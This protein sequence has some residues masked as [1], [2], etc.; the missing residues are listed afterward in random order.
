M[1]RR[2]AHRRGR[3]VAGTRWRARSIAAR[4]RRDDEHP[5]APPRVLGASSS[6]S[7]RGSGS[8]TQDFQTMA[9]TG[10][11]EDRFQLIWGV[12]AAEPGLLQLGPDRR[13]DRRAWPRTESGRSRSCGGPRSG[14][15]PA[16][17]RPPARRTAATSRRG[18]TSSRR[19]WRAT[20]AGGSY[21]ATDYRAAIRRGRQAAA[22]PVLADLER[23]QPEEVLRAEPIGREVRPA[24]RISHDAIKTKDPQAQIVL[25][26][27]PG[28][29]D[30]NAWDFLDSLYSVPGTEDHFDAVAL[31]PYAP[32]LDQLRAGDRADPRGDEGARRPG[33]AAVDH[34]ARLG[35]A[36]P[37]RFGLNKGLERSESGCSP[38]PS[39]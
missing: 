38:A 28:Y 6:A 4:R 7:P 3:P 8:M 18:R 29:G 24:A 15:P 1:N 13:A 39:S 33:H 5:D 37:D 25:A 16:T 32:D 23:A 19:R 2:Q 26:G 35:S 9:A 31:H 36:P 20:D 10:I 17:A 27:M 34:R 12:G 14:W 21:W 11:G 30:V 22:D